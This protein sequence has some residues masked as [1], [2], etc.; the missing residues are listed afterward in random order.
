MLIIADSILVQPYRPGRRS[1]QHNAIHAAFL[2]EQLHNLNGRAKE[3]VSGPAAPDNAPRAFSIVNRHPRLDAAV[4]HKDDVATSQMAGQSA[5]RKINN[6]SK[7]DFP[8]WAL[9]AGTEK[10]GSDL[11]RKIVCISTAIPIKR[12]IESLSSLWTVPGRP[13]A[14]QYASPAAMNGRKSGS[15]PFPADDEF[16]ARCSF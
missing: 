4:L 15:E 5:G 12:I 16:K 14:H 10:H 8:T 7:V 13:E 11:S 1:A 3:V 2:L 6:R 9:M